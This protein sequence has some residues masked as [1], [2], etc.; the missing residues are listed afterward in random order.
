M[1]YKTLTWVRCSSVPVHSQSSSLPLGASCSRGKEQAQPDVPENTDNV[2][3]FFTFNKSSKNILHLEN[4]NKRFHNVFI[5][6]KFLGISYCKG[7]VPKHSSFLALYL[8]VL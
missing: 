5:I 8:I 7:A 1:K 3:K 6:K 2:N 4:K